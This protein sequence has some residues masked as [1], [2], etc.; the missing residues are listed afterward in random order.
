MIYLLVSATIALNKS[1]FLTSHQVNL[2]LKESFPW[3]KKEKKFFMNEERTEGTLTTFDN[4]VTE[5]CTIT[6]RSLVG[7]KSLTVI[8]CP[9]NKY[10]AHVTANKDGTTKVENEIRCRDISK[11]RLTGKSD[12]SSITITY[13][14]KSPFDGNIVKDGPIKTQTQSYIYKDASTKV[15]NDAIDDCIKQDKEA[16]CRAIVRAEECERNP[17]CK[18]AQ[19][20]KNECRAFHEE[21]GIMTSE[22]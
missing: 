9:Q 12:Q 13:G 11:R 8:S 4:T 10:I 14:K 5:E 1:S 19:R 2:N 21:N 3:K 22:D 6:Y 17:H 18:A 15:I 16:S 7:A 20:S